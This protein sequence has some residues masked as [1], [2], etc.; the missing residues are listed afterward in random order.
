MHEIRKALGRTIEMRTPTKAAAKSEAPLFTGAQFANIGLTLIAY[1]KGCVLVQEMVEFIERE[2]CVDS[3]VPPDVVRKVLSM[4]EDFV[5]V[6][7]ELRPVV[8][9][10]TKFR[11]KHELLDLHVQDLVDHMDDEVFSLEVD[12]AALGIGR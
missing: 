9:A 12:A 8:E 7:D 2:S 4:A 1:V 6:L 10:W 5:Y 11:A 3:T